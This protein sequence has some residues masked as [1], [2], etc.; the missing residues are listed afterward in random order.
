MS[1]AKP[2]I[3]D[4]LA[5][6]YASAALCGIWS[7]QGRVLSEGSIEDVASDQQV[8]KAYLGRSRTLQGDAGATVPS[9]PSLN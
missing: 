6:R 4:V 7:P 3:P 9:S 8:V 1:D 2:I 5:S